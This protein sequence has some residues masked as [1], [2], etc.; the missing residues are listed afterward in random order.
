M[1]ACR[2]FSGKQQKQ[3]TSNGAM[4]CPDTQHCLF[5][6]VPC[7]CVDI[8]TCVGAFTCACKHV[9]NTKPMV[10][11]K[12]PPTKTVILCPP[13]P[14]QEHA[15]K[16]P[17]RMQPLICPKQDYAAHPGLFGHTTTSREGSSACP[18]LCARLQSLT[19][20]WGLLC[21]LVWPAQSK[22]SIASCSTSSSECGPHHYC[23]QHSLRHLLLC[24]SHQPQPPHPSLEALASADQK[25]GS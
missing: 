12:T 11:K 5:T 6:H 4:V 1:G 23:R 9:P 22:S 8:R 2:R 21:V 14:V 19:I 16:L 20:T 18:F 7:R 15:V 25:E 13:V 17:T 3:E 10:E 24:H